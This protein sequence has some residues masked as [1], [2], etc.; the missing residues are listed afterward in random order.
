MAEE[1]G[2]DRSE[3]PTQRRREEARRQ[4]RVA[5]SNDL[6]SGLLLL[7]A[8]AL[9]HL[10][11]NRLAGGLILDAQL[12]LQNS[13]GVEL[14]QAQARSLLTGLASRG[15]ELLGLLLGLL[16]VSVMF[17]GVLQVGVHFLPGLLSIDPGRLN[18]ANGWSRLFSAGTM[19]RTL[20][21]LLKIAGIGFVAWWVLRG[22][23]DQI[24]KF[25]DGS[26]APA[27]SQGWGLG[28]RLGLMIAAA[29]SGSV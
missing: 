8:L 9:L 12:H 18:P 26:A 17:V 25:G 5:F 7:V 11:G 2:Q 1:F 6:T 3:A 15:L 10:T 21:A 27:I 24:S 29:I 23:V 22:R 16:V 4:G 28:M 14:D 20:T 13:G 19:V